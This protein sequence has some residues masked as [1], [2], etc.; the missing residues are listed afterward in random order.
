MKRNVPQ[1]KMSRKDS[2]VLSKKD[3]LVLSR[4]DSLVVEKDVT[5]GS[6][7]GEIQDLFDQSRLR[8]A[9]CQVENCNPQLT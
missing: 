5:G 1:R 8:D 2:L 3:S 4:K 7:L 9:F 6:K